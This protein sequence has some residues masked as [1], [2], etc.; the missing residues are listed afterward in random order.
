MKKLL[1]VLMVALGATVVI[2]AECADITIPELKA[3][4]AAKT[5]TLLDAN[6]TESWQAGHI[7]GAV[8]FTTQKDKLAELLPADKSALVVAYCGGPQ[9]MAYKAAAKAAVKLGYTNVKHLSAGIHGW[10][11]AGETVEKGL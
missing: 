8:D 6:G 9:C 3:A 7:P 4:I 11:D 2:A 10:K 5:V 1:A